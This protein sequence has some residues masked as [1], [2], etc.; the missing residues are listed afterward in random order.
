VL[1]LG[2][3]W[4]GYRSGAPVLQGCSLHVASGEIVALLG[5]NGVGKS[6]LMRT[7]VGLLRVSH[8][9]ILLDGSEVTRLPIHQRARLGIGYAPQ[10][11]EVFPLLTV[12]ENLR[13][14]V[15]GSPAGV[16]A[17]LDAI[18]EDFP[19]LRERFGQRA[20]SLSGGQQQLLILARALVARPRLLLL[21]EPTEGIQPS[22]VQ[23]IAERVRVAREQGIGVLFA[24]QNLEFTALLA[25][26]VYAIDKGR[27]VQEVAPDSI[28]HDVEFQ[29]QFIGV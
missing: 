29:H 16:R 15:R 6:T 27:I 20:G 7:V 22:I 11:R 24:E 13:V 19:V 17:R 4:A 23:E 28:L 3:V 18:L 25:E 5:R 10:A 8:G 2:D 1:Q 26:R 9:S 14:G 21:D 12:G